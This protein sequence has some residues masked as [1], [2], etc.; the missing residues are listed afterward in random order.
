M[1]DTT[2]HPNLQRSL[3]EAFVAFERRRGA[4][5]LADLRMAGSAKVMFPRVPGDVPEVVLLNTSGGLT[6]GDRLSLC[7]QVGAGCRVLA[8]TQTAERGYAALGKPARVLVRAHVGAGA[9]LDW[10]PQETLL[11]QTADLQ[12]HTEIEL[13]ADA[14]CLVAECLV[15]GRQAMGETLRSASLRDH[16][17][18]RRDG[19]PVWAESFF[20]DDGVLADGSGALLN[21]ARALAVVCLVARGAEDAVA[22]LRAMLGA[23]GA[24]SGWDGRCVVRLS[25]PDGW[26]LRQDLA[27]VL[28]ILTGRMLPRVWQ[29]GGI[30]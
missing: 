8:T 29:S 21:G 30:Q 26:P 15:L 12:R 5:R 23:R 6:G 1:L 20:L 9:R 27:Q 22:P 13:A 28:Q 2:H 11:Y 3:G 14:E 4:T 10:M 19:R 16:R 25:A 17:M 24:V 18:I 7:L